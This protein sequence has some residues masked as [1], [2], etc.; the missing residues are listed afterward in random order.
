MLSRSASAAGGV[1]ALS[2]IIVQRLGF[3]LVEVDR[4]Q[5]VHH[6]VRISADRGGKVRV[7]PE[8]EAVMADV[9]GAVAGL[10]HRAE[11]EDLDG[12][13]LGLFLDLGKEVV[14]RKGDVLAAADRA[15]LVAQVAGELP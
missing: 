11:G 10:G 8:S 14:Q 12:A 3:P 4:Q 6:Q 5:S 13:E 1:F 7:E 15:H 2:S 9:I